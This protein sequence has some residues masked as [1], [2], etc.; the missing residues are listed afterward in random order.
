ML[1]KTIIFYN[2]ERQMFD[3]HQAK[4]HLGKENEVLS[5][6][7]NLDADLECFILIDST[8]TKISGLVLNNVLDTIIW[9]ISKYD[10]YKDFS[11]ALENIN[12]F[13]KT[14]QN[15]GNKIKDLSIFIWI[16]SKHSLTFSTIWK[17]S[18]YLIKKD[19][20]LIEIT[21]KSDIKKEFSFISSGDIND[22]EV[23]IISSN[24]LLDFLSKSDLRDS[25][26]LHKSEDILVNL[27]NIIKWEKLDDNISLFS[28]KN[29]YFLISKENDKVHIY[30][31]KCK[32]YALKMFDNK[33]V[34]STIANLMLWK[35]KLACQSRMIK[36]IVFV[37]WILVSVIFLY[38][39]IGTILSSSSNVQN[40]E[41][42][43]VK[44]E[45]I[46]TYIR[47]ANENIANPDIFSLNIKK[48]DDL[49]LEINQKELFLNDIQKIMEDITIIKKQFN[50]VESFEE[51]KEKLISDGIDAGARSIVQ[52]SWKI[53]VIS[54]NTVFG[55]I[56]S[57]QEVKKYV[58]D[59]LGNADA[60]KEA[61]VFNNS[62]LILTEQS[63]V[64]NFTTNGFFRYVDSVGQT[65]WEK[66][67]QVE[68]FGQN[69]YTINNAGNQIVKH[70]R[71]GDNFNAGIPYLKDE[72][73]AAIWN[74]LSIGI[75]GGIYILKKDLSIV[76]VYASPKYRMENILI[77]KLPKNYTV[78]E[79]S[80]VVLKTR[81]ELS[82]VY[83]LMNNKIW[84]FK[85]NSKS[86]L[87][88]KNLTYI[89]QIEGKTAKIKDFYIAHDGEL[90]VLNE[91]WIYKLTF[92]V[93]DT[94]L[95]LR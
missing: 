80:P 43:K 93:S 14:W 67:T 39:I 78:E 28:I 22:G 29:N 58:F 62:I 1:E 90:L 33:F 64:V 2:N 3:I 54:K 65:S 72:D 85:P 52:I 34:K 60:F 27:E 45:E 36:N 38:N 7:I 13:I 21:E 82:Y 76:K 55:P 50:G 5:K 88:T 9:N 20:E 68:S 48:A 84:V 53:Y 51:E 17:A 79:N 47:I 77:N 4:I 92:E 94:K 71:N 37:L 75:D 66:M 24:R 49:I 26:S 83:L 74:I 41:A 63:K 10:T 15:D 89:G 23:V 32:Y 81:Q 8:D 30:G 40:I 95:L 86:Y 61:I 91:K 59:K 35:E 42:S 18:G 46:R 44:L 11:N 87:D 19:G 31:T 25:G 12:L 56:L 73:A 16:L 70:T 6:H 57:G 69:I